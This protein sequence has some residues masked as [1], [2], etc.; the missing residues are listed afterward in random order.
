MNKKKK[1]TCSFCN[2]SDSIMSKEN[3][4]LWYLDSTSA[5][6]KSM[7]IHNHENVQ[8]D[9]NDSNILTHDRVIAP[10]LVFGLTIVRDADRS[11]NDEVIL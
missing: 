8:V 7:R 1:Q 10:L 5:Y 9:I 2:R 11:L 6:G 4:E 3:D